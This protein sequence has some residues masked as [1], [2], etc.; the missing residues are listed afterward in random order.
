MSRI[1]R[2]EVPSPVIRRI[3]PPTTQSVPPPVVN[4]IAPPAVD[5]PNV[6]IE[7]PTIDIP[8]EQDFNGVAPQ[9]QQT[10]STPPEDTRD[11]PTTPS[12]PPPTTTTTQ[13]TIDVGG[14]E[15]PLPEAAPLVA[16]GATAVVTTGVALTSTIV[17]N[18]LKDT[19]LEPL[20]KRMSARKKKIKIKQV[21]PVLHYV[22]DDDG[23]VDIYQYSQ[24]GTKLI[25]TTQDVERYLRDQVELDSLYEYDN[26]LIIDDII[27]PKFTKEGAKRFRSHFAPAKAIAKKLSAKF[28]I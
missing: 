8:A 14:V 24:K 12:T 26:K 18:K 6:R 2:I 7:Y 16:A 27:Q 15:V 3:P 23:G 11:L 9:E 28:S 25:H 4:G 21:K 17:L 10:Q 1:P 19:L 22:L 20:M 13:P 5:V